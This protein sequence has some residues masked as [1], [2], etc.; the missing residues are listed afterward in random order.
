MNLLGRHLTGLAD[1]SGRENRQ[2]FWLWILIV[3]GVQFVVGM[4]VSTVMMT[5][6]FNGMTALAGRGQDYIDQHPEIVGQ[7]MMQSMA[8]MMRNMMVFSAVMAVVSMALI[9]AAAT[10]RLHDGDRSG[11][12]AAPVFALHIGMPLAYMAVLPRFFEVFGKIRPDMSPE[13]ANA[14]MLPMMQTIMPLSLIG[15]VGFVVMIVLIVFLAMP[16][17]PG[18]NRY[19]PD[20]L[21]M[22]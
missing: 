2:P 4:I 3:Y 18:P 14:A 12:W 8:P 5:G 22:Q 15:M 20:P 13:Q 7:I 17:T 1:F 16:G 19:G 6:M 11:W 10:R 9:A 21:G